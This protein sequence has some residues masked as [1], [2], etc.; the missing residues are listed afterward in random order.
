MKLGV[1]TMALG[2]EPS[3]EEGLGTFKAIGFDHLLLIGVSGA[4]P[5][6]SDGTCPDAMPDLLRSDPEHVM[7]AV[8]NAGLKIASVYFAGEAGAMDIESDE[9]AA[10]T[11]RRLTEYGSAALALGCTCLAHPVQSCGRT[12]LPTAEKVE[13][14]KR[15]ARCMS[16]AAESHH[17]RGLRVCVDVHY[18]A[19]VEGLEDCRLL[20]D[21]L[22]SPNAGLL[23]NTGHL[24][25]AE[26]YGWLLVGEYPD[27]IP[28][29]GWKDHSL[30]PDRPRPMHSV[31]L[32]AGDC[33]LDLYVR[34][35]RR[36]PAERV[37]VLNCEHVPDPERPEALKRSLAYLRRL[38]EE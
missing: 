28:C 14:I 13:P 11:S 25:T 16:E 27:R 2:R 4:R 9:G 5:V 10:R 17:D 33:P 30:A 12:R 19:W 36:H 6:A 22:A 37:H 23:M 34:E 24:A 32:G 31:E 29:V 20:L 15:L 18:R 35:M 1:V 26:A 7:V 21:S 3:F 38:W 8:R